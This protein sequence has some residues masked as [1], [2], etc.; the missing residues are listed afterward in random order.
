MRVVVPNITSGLI[1]GLRPANERRRYKG[2]DV[3]HWLGADL[4][5]DLQPEIVW[6]AREL[7]EISHSMSDFYLISGILPEAKYLKSGKKKKPWK[8]PCL[9]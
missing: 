5:W 3:S 8:S 9:F 4:E 6:V 7:E 1:L 2:N